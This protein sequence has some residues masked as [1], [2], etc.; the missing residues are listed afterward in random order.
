MTLPLLLFALL[1][2]LLCGALF[3]TLRGGSGWQ[4]LL[5]LFMSVLGFA[6]G[7]GLSMWR[8]WHFLT[9]GALEIGAGLIGSL[10]FLALG[11]WLSRI[12][13]NEKNSV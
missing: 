9:F 5:Y 8:G 10:L 12:E 1:L 11:D 6:A 7:Q 2:A 13:S 3:H 4:L